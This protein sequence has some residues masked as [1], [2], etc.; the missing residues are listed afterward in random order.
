MTKTL[1]IVK[2]IFGLVFGVIAPGM[3][4]WAGVGWVISEGVKWIF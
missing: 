4:F 1:T 3:A 2:S